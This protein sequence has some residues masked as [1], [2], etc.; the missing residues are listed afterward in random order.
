MSLTNVAKTFGGVRALIDVDFEVL[1]GEVHCLAGENGCGK[2]T[3]IKIISGVHAPEPGAVMRFSGE[4]VSH[5]TPGTARAFG[6]QVIW[7]DLA[8]FPEMTVAENIAFESNL[9]AMPRL[10]S[11]RAMRERAAAAMAR[12]HVDLPLERPLRELDIAQRQV[13]AICRA[14]VADARLVFMDEPTASLDPG[15]DRGALRRRRA[16]QARRHRHRLRQPSAWP[17]SWP[18]PSGSP[19]SATAARSASTRQPR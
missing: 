7:Q 9:G 4:P 14:L 16:A 1:E 12:L 8:L 3:L 18:S 17:R 15:R 13:V 5:L 2:S 19:C 10:V 11:Y 6:I